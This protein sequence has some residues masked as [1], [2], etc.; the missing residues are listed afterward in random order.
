MYMMIALSGLLVL[1]LV[2]MS[3]RFAANFRKFN[4]HFHVIKPLLVCIAVYSV[5]F[6]FWM[7][8]ILEF[9]ILQMIL[10]WLLLVGML[11]AYRLPLRL[12]PRVALMVMC[13]TLFCV[14]YFGSL[15]WLGKKNFDFYYVE[16]MALDRSLKED[17]IVILENEWILKDYVR[18]FSKAKVIAAD[19]PGF[20]RDA[21]SNAT[22][23]AIRNKHKV[24]IYRPYLNKGG[25]P[26][27]PITSY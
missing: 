24:Y 19:E 15:K 14:N 10:I 12:S 2:T 20:N 23:K 16:V 6:L 25:S 1:M 21:A 3:F 17:D 18:Y 5:F 7:P 8:E 11:P 26:W 27:I 9:W 4:L 13:V 22:E